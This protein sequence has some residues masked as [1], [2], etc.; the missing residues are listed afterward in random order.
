MYLITIDDDYE[1]QYFLW[2]EEKLKPLLEQDGIELFNY[3]DIRYNE[4]STRSFSVRQRLLNTTPEKESSDYKL[5]MDAI[6]SYGLPP[7][8]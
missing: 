4:I 3:T 6:K 2:L 8:Y 1:E 5:I 7:L